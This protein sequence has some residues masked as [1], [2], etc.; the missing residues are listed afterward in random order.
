MMRPVALALPALALLLATGAGAQEVAPEAGGGRV[1]RIG[2]HA[3]PPFAMRGDDGAWEGISIA[4][5]ADVAGRAGFRYEL[6]EVEQPE[7]IAGVAAGRL[8]G[9]I[10]ALSPT[11]ESER[12]VDF[13]NSYFLSGLAV[14]VP[15]TRPATVREIFGA[16]ASREFRGVLAVLLG[17]TLVAGALVWAL[18]RRRNPEFER[19]AARGMFSGF[20]WATATMTT[21]GYGDKAPV[22]VAGRLLG[23]AWMIATL[24]LVALAT[25]QLSAT[26]TAERL[27]GGVTSVSDLARVRVGALADGPAVA[28]LHALGARVERFPSVLAGLQAVASGRIDAF[29]HDE[30]VLAWERGTVGNVAL[31][32]LRFGVED[33]AMALPEG[34]AAREAVNRAI[35]DTLASD[36]WLGTLRYYLGVD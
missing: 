31:A 4:L 29:V 3:A 34:S 18:E 16:M 15:E 9:A 33:Y 13:S 1:L 20:W 21:V 35:V 36:A 24:G 6:V 2:T 10:A 30:P 8:D 27:R 23:I 28:P 32:P 14:A 25:A 12:A 22:T 19:A 26:L 17:L 7:L 11:S 5:L